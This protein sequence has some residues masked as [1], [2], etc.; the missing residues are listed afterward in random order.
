MLLGHVDVDAPP[1]A[2]GAG[3]RA[4]LTSAV[5]GTERLDEF[6]AAGAAMDRRR[7]VDYALERLDLHGAPTM[8]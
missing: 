3:L 8:S 2:L 4:A 5:A 6:K 1:W 7:A